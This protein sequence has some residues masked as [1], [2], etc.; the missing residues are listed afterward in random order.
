MHDTADLVRLDGVSMKYRL[1]RQRRPSFKEY[2]L[3]WVRGAL[4]YEDLWGLSDV[5]L[6]I[7]RG[8]S[9]GIVGRN[10]AGK[11]T[12]LKVISRVLEPTAGKV[13]IRG[14]IVPV[15]DFSA[16]LDPELSGLENIYLNALF[17][18]R[19]RAEVHAARDAIVAASGLGS[20]IDS[21]LRNY[22][23]GM[24]ARLGFS[25]AT[26][27][28]PDVLILDEVLA[29]GDA[30]FVAGC[31]ARLQQF[32]N[33]GATVLVVSHSPQEIQ[34]TCRRAIWIDGGRVHADGPT[35]SV[36]A[37]YAEFVETRRAAIGTPDRQA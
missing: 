22:S 16:G 9:I 1:A 20:F 12:L 17:L 37:A 32:R 5:S 33:E 13:V 14:R 6:R 18:G 21:P 23:A 7:G 31:H 29:V 30:G 34:A 28:R 2:A 26:A 8:E 3:H 36:L 4:V 25:V 15:L 11:S 10:G 19:T 27:W 35:D 24:V